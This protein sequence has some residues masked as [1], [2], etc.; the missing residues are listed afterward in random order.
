MIRSVFLILC[1]ACFQAN[2]ESSPK[3]SAQEESEDEAMITQV[4]QMGKSMKDALAKAMEKFKGMT[5]ADVSATP[6]M[7]GLGGKAMNNVNKQIDDL[8]KLSDEIQ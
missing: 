5:G 6:E 7:N 2:A 8:N 4:E 1:L 3:T